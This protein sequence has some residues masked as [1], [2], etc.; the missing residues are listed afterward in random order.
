MKGVFFMP[1][2]AYLMFKDIKIAKLIFGDYSFKLVDT[3]VDMFPVH[4]DAELHR[5]WS[6]RQTPYSKT[7]M[8]DVYKFL[9]INNPI[10]FIKITKFAS[11]NDCFWVK[12]DNK[13]SWSNVNLFTNHFTKAISDIEMSGIAQGIPSHNIYSPS[14]TLGG[15][16][17]KTWVHKDGKIVLLKASHHQD[18]ELKDS[19]IYSEVLTNQVCE[20]LGIKDYVKY[21]LAKY[22]DVNVCACDS[23]TNE[24]IMYYPLV[25]YIQGYPTYEQVKSLLCK[26]RQFY[27]MTLLDYLTLNID[28][29]TGNYGYLVSSNN[30]SIMGMSPIFDNNYSLLSEKAIIKANR[31][32]IFD[33]VLTTES[34][35]GCLIHDLALY[36]IKD[37]PES[38]ELCRRLLKF[39]FKHIGNIDR[40]RLKKLSYIVRLQAKELIRL[41]S[42]F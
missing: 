19:S 1:I 8:M 33:Y 20:A 26:Y 15:S 2:E 40:R 27:L 37:F 14:F 11:V 10:D 4:S 24:N 39:E 16:F 13:Q 7:H 12:T 23:F 3:Y 25:Y 9:N 18:G 31:D 30:F 6:L 35:F 41:S 5:W 22:K 32:E 42:N 38:I 21:R 34:R 28:R 17:P 36:L 29:H